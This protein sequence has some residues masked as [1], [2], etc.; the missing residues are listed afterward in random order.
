MPT[1]R[2][3]PADKANAL[4]LS[5]CHL[6]YVMLHGKRLIADYVLTCSQ[7][8]SARIKSQLFQLICKAV[9]LWQVV[10]CNCTIT[11]VRMKSDSQVTFANVHDSIH[12]ND[13]W[14]WNLEQTAFPRIISR[15]SFGRFSD[16]WVLPFA[17]GLLIV[18]YHLKNS[19]RLRLND[20]LL[21][22][23]RH[24]MAN[25]PKCVPAVSLQYFAD[26]LMRRY[27]KRFSMFFLYRNKNEFSNFV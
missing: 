20:V 9:A 17:V 18:N 19:R 5:I 2:D 1:S 3:D 25:K 16:T 26:T 11:H 6:S 23:R 8:Q 21:W 24:N 12:I 7:L 22:N 10:V 13:V 14:P 4:I 27:N 15:Q